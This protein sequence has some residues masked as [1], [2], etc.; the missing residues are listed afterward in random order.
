MSIRIDDWFV[1]GNAQKTNSDWNAESGFA[2]ILNKPTNLAHTTGNE[3]I[4]G[5]KTFSTIPISVTPDSSS[6][7]GSVATTEFVNSKVSSH[8]NNITSHADI[9]QEIIDTNSNISTSIDSHNNSSTSHND[10]RQALSQTNTNIATSIENHNS[11]LT[12]HSDLRQSVGNNTSAIES[13]TSDLSQ[14][15]EQRNGDVIYLQQ[16]IDALSSKGDVADIVGTY[17]DLLN[18][19]TS[20]LLNKSIIKV[21]TDST[22]DNASSYYKWNSNTSSFTYIGSEAPTYNKTEIDE[23]YGNSVHKTGNET[24]AGTKTF[25]NIPVITGGNSTNEGGEIQLAP[26]ANNSSYSKGYVDVY[27]STPSDDTTHCIR[28]RIGNTQGVSVYTDGTATA[29]APGATNDTSDTHVVTVGW[30][31]DPTKSTNIVH[32]SG[33]ETITGNKTFTSTVMNQS[34]SQYPNAFIHKNTLIPSNYENPSSA[35]NAVLTGLY[36]N[37]GDFCSYIQSGKSTGGVTNLTL[38]VRNRASSSDSNRNG[39]MGI[40][41]DSNGNVYT[42]A[43]TPDLSDNSTKIATTAWCRSTS[44]DLVHKSGTETIT[45]SKT[46][47]STLI[48]T[49]NLTSKANNSAWDDASRESAE[50]KQINFMDKNSVRINSLQTTWYTNGTRS[51]ELQVKN[52]DNTAWEVPLRINTPNSTTGGASTVAAKLKWTFDETIQGTAYRALWADL[53]EH[54]LVD[55]QYPKGTLVQFGGEKEITIAKNRVNAVISSEPGFILN[56]EMEDSQAVAL[57]GRVPVRVI[58][59][60]KKFDKIALSYIDGVGCVNNDS[61]DYIGIALVNK[62][63]SEEG[64][65][66]CS[67]RINL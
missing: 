46:F 60:V 13:L 53:A 34:S 50:Y 40:F 36:S 45:G 33:D 20:T 64:L 23:M 38:N 17:Q 49:S 43:P 27:S 9:R 52:Y 67:V 22:H 28:L 6:N 42:Q 47:S 32:R 48:L 16:Q 37:A 59:K 65:V 5:V 31:S 41:I 3:T 12:A 29:T 66:L 8:N 14:E 44:N 51:F 39:T 63:D 19:D 1:A 2:Q 30:V 55:K 24:I 57:I 25:S 4:S 18:Y 26:V 56:G 11:S 62:D 61:D 54:Y 15:T 58:G 21:L 7:D 35:V 10:L